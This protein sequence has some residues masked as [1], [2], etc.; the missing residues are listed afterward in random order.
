ML[1]LL[2]VMLLMFTASACLLVRPI[3]ENV[4]TVIPGEVYRSAQLSPGRLEKLIE[5]QK[6]RSVLNL[7]G[8]SPGVEWYDQERAV[9]AK[10]GATHIDYELGSAKEVTPEQ[11]RELIALMDK[12]PKPILIH[13]WGGADRTGLASALYLYKLAEKKDLAAGALSFRYHHLGWTSAGAMDRSFAAFVKA[14]VAAVKAEAAV[15]KA[16]A[17]AVADAAG[18]P[19]AA[20]LPSSR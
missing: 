2:L 13:C 20:G 4:H 14:E 15:L 7:R 12:A 3:V 10:T 8:A 19:G 18:V 16:K 9:A 11:A 5:T 6:I 17:S 1:R